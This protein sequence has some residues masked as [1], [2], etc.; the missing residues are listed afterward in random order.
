MLR[1]I[2]AGVIVVSLMQP[3][4][5]S[6]QGTAPTPMTTG[7]P[8][9]A[10]S[11]PGPAAAAKP[12]TSAGDA[13]YATL[14][15]RYFDDTF[16]LEPAS[17]TAAGLHTYDALLGD[18][19]AARY[20][21]QV[22][23]DRRYL[24]ELAGL[25]NMPLGPRTSL[26]AQMLANALRDDALL[27]GTMQSWR[28]RPDMYVGGASFAIFALMSRPFAPASQR[29]RDV[30]AREN[31]IPRYFAQA[32]QNLTTVD[33]ASA[34]IALDDV[35][36][37]AAFFSRTVPL[38]FAGVGD[39][40]LRRAFF[41]STA[42]AVGAARDFATWLKRGPVARPRGTYAIGADAYAKRLEYEEGIAIPLDTYLRVGTIA[43]AR[44]RA[45]MVAVAHRIDPHASVQ[46]V[47]SR[48][49]RVH[50]TA[51][52]LIPAAQA[53]LVRLRAFDIAHHIITLPADANIRVTLTPEF[54]RATT[55][56]SM[57]AP[58]PL[59]QHAKQAFYNVTPVDPR[60][61]KRVQELYLETFND[62]E[63]PIVSAHEVYPGHFANFAVDRHLPLT[64]TEK[65]LSATSFV[66]GW[67]HYSE[68]MIVEEG[69]GNGDPR[70][71]LMQL[72]EAILRNARYV[73]GVKLH[74]QG[75]TIP[76]AIA[77]FEREAFLD[78]AEAR[79]ESRRGTQDATYGYY[80]LGK[81]AILKLRADYKKKLGA[82][83]TLQRFHD[84]LLSYGDP[85][86][87]LLRKLLL[88]PD[89]DGV[90]LDPSLER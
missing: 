35:D 53:D 21:R 28:H 70:V 13:A 41:A 56:A 30:V 25:A 61:S 60:D 87:P 73:V 52:R 14:A 34:A 75:M 83:F 40:A 26:D 79:I 4:A 82:S 9:P 67:A 8:S 46:N 64:L 5:G 33:A 17:A 48:V 71:H 12:S 32:K 85:P 62:F 81:L 31:A 10:A 6:A 51:Q 63:R 55:V 38:A 37:S 76:Q 47:V 20:A 2:A 24:G 44:T 68:Q 49:E 43:L 89:D 65:L 69:W 19:S 42:R 80:T 45:Q 11:T 86:L 1:R 54:E 15:Q 84:D 90:L 22:A 72:K 3:L 58:G 16:R 27:N 77:F 57:D 18:H 23:L 66:E 88:G 39:A 29:M 59:E 78:P 36:G 74:T 50:P 7:T